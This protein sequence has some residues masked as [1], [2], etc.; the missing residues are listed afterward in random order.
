VFLAGDADRRVVV[1]RVDTA[2]RAGL[3][4]VGDRHRITGV[5]HLAAAPHD[6]P[7]PLEY[8]RLE[9]VALLNVLD[10][11][12]AW[13]ARRFAVAS[14]I[15]AYA[16]VDDVP[17]REDAPLPAVAP[18]QIPVV[19]KAAELF[20]ALVG[21]HAGFEAINLRIGTVWGPLGLPDNPFFALPRLLSAAVWG[22]DPDLAPPRPPAYTEDVTDL[23]YVKDCGRA[24]ALLMCAERLH[25]RVYN[26]S[27]GR[28]AR[29]DEAVAA[30][31]TAV[32][33]AGIVLPPGRSP[34]RPRDE[35][36]DIARLQEDTGFRPEYDVGRAVGDYVAWLRRHDR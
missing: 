32:P 24:I 25:H 15:A 13:G 29:Y 33:G 14:T 3:L 2:D 26:V 6:L 17:W 9:T 30:I 12:R 11:T 27:S 21:D 8:L 23:C 19:K 16:G 10:A 35:Y 4:A 31:N 22:V 18:H 34:E 1:E 36:L 5:V 20:A 28:P 7:D